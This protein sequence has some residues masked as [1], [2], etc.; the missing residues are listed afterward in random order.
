MA[1][2]VP[3]VFALAPGVHGAA[4]FIGY[5]TTEGQKLYK[6]M[7]APLTNK[8]DCTPKNLK[9]FLSALSDRVGEYGWDTCLEIPADIANPGADLRDLLT[10]YG[11]LSIQQVT[12]HANTYVA[13]QTRQAQNSYAMY[14]CIMS[15]LTSTARTKIM[16]KEGEYTVNGI[17]SGAC[18]LKVVIRA[19]Y[20]DS[21]ATSLFIRDAISNLDEYM[22]SVDSDIDKFNEHVE[23]LVD[24]LSA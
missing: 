19:S 23:D 9:V 15:S 1:A 22:V 21:N 17:R 24:S 2:A 13:Q 10:E 18:L 7:K 12:A 11:R 14:Q 20:L 6:A 3:P 4:A 5:G 8:F 16:L